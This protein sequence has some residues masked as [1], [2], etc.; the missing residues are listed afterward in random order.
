M[1]DLFRPTTMAMCFKFAGICSVQHLSSVDIGW[2]KV[3]SCLCYD[4]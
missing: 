1:D 4:V 3:V 2:F